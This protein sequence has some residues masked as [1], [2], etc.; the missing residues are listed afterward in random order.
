MPGNRDTRAADISICRAIYRN[1]NAGSVCKNVMRQVGKRECKD[2]T[3]AE[4]EIE[5]WHATCRLQTA[6]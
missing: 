1:E 5:V 3:V 2:V 4:A 6:T